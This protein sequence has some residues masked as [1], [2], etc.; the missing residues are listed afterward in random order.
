MN[1]ESTKHLYED[2][3]KL[4]V[5]FEVTLGPLPHRS[6]SQ[7]NHH[8]NLLILKKCLALVECWNE[9]H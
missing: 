6:Q 7:Y 2:N 3:K 4:K 1:N 9:V 5:K 8:H